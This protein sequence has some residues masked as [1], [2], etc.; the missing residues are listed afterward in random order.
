MRVLVTGGCGFIGSHIVEYH[1]ARGDKVHVVDDITTGSLRNIIPF[2]TNPNFYFDKADI[3]TWHDLTSSVATADR[4]YHM[5]AVVGIYRVLAEPI[6]VISTNI[7]G[8]ERVLRAVHATGCKQRVIIASSSEVYGQSTKPELT[9]TD[10]LIVESA[11]QP[12]WSYAISKLTDEALGVAY[13]HAAKMA[14]TMVRFFNTIG[15]RQTG[16]YGMVVPNFVQ[17]ACS[18][19]PITVFGDGTQTRCFVDVRDVVVSLDMLAN[20]TRSVGEIVNVGN[21]Y[22]ISI[23]DLATL[24]KQH[25]KSSSDIIHIPYEEAYKQEFVDIMRRKPNLDKFHALTNFK[26][27]WTLEGTID[28]LIDHCKKKQQVT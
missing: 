28:F 10:R 23:N 7:A 27:K 19:E 5:A 18:G 25:A 8:T 22:E 9:E 20:N 26:H 14:I 17:Q 6:K 3:I 4:I 21:N 11:A 13:N 2:E 16:R 1:L 24:V 15:P 12:R